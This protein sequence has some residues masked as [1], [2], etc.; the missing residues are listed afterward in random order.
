MRQTKLGGLRGDI[1][2]RLQLGVSAALGFSASGQYAVVLSRPSIDSQ[3]QQLRLR[4]FKMRKKG[5]DFSLNA[6]ADVQG[7]FGNRP[8]TFASHAGSAS[9]SAFDEPARG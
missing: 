1:G 6:G 9:R 3:D 5:W 4:L 2:L 8:E 7:N